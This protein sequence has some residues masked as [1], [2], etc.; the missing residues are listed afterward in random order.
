MYHKRSGDFPA[1][2]E[3]DTMPTIRRSAERGHF[4]HGWLE[5]YHSFSFAEYHDPAY[6]GVSHLRVINEDWIAAGQ[7]FPTHPHRDMEIITYVLEGALAHSDSMGNKT[8]IRAGEVQRMSAGK[9]IQH[10]EFNASESNPVHLLQIWIIPAQTGL[11]AGYQQKA[12]SQAE[13]RGRLCLIAAPDGRD[14]ALTVH[15]DMFLY[16]S[17]LRD[18]ETLEYSLATRRLAYLQ[19]ARGE[20]ILEGKTLWEGDGATILDQMS[21]RGTAEGGE[22][23]LFDLPIVR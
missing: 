12:F 11:P 17:D 7:G 20:L 16:A 13:K 5:T 6:M 8:V 10:S 4:N 19:V 3:A 14:N 9:G 2:T 15:Q 18:G 21:L 1:H 23:L 22:F